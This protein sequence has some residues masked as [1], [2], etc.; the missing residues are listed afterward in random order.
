MLGCVTW[1]FCKFSSNPTTFIL[2]TILLRLDMGEEGGKVDSIEGEVN[3][4]AEGS[5]E[6]GDAAVATAAI[7]PMQ[8]LPLGVERRQWRVKPKPVK[9]EQNQDKSPKSNEVDVEI[10]TPVEVEQCQ[11]QSLV[12]P[13][14]ERSKDAMGEKKATRSLDKGKSKVTGAQL[15]DR[16][17]GIMGSTTQVHIK[18]PT[19]TSV[20]NTFRSL[21]KGRRGTYHDSNS[22]SNQFNVLFEDDTDDVED[23][24][25]E[26][27]IPNGEDIGSV[28]GD[29]LDQ[30]MVEADRLAFTD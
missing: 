15:E 16:N 28:S 26:K 4:V 20:I 6:K 27:E 13:G 12:D 25:I 19:V 3:N 8:L 22:S 9:Q 23:G 24:P 30:D 14:M 2:T 29:D 11:S 5:L 7:H 10:P 1:V 17:K 21:A 18:A